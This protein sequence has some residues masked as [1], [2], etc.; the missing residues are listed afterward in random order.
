ML[1]AFQPVEIADQVAV[2]VFRALAQRLKHL[3]GRTPRSAVAGAELLHDHAALRVD[4]LG[5]EGDEVRP[6]V[7]D[8]QRTVDDA[9]ARGRDILHHVRSHVPAGTGVEV[10]AE[11]HAYLL[12]VFDHLLAGEVLRAVEGHVLEEVGEAL[13]RVV[14]L[15]GSHVV[16]DVEIRLSFR[17]F[18]VADVIGHSVF[19]FT[20]PDI[21]VRR[22][23]LHRVELGHC[24]RHCEGGCNQHC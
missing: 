1:E 24:A 23:R 21:L 14:L 8:Q 16:Q 22:D 20:R 12:Q 2:L 19:E 18:V 3:H 11:L 9:L 4:L 6:V 15:D 13:L 17:L 10:G 5:L 7:Q